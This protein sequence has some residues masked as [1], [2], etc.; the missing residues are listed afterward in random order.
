MSLAKLQ[1]LVYQQ[2]S[3]SITKGRLTHAYLFEGASGTGKKEMALW[4]TQ[5]IFCLSEGARPCA[6]C[7]NCQRILVG[8][9]PD[10]LTII[11]EG[12]TI[13]VDQIRD[14]KATFIKSGMESQKKVVIIEEAEKLTTSASNSLLKFIEEPDGD[15]IILF[16]T[17]SKARILPTIQSRCQLLHFN[18]LSKKQLSL[19]L[20]AEDIPPIEAKFLAELT[21]SKE[22][23]IEFYRDEWFNESK[24]AV[25]KWVTYLVESNHFSFVF[26][27]QKLVKQFKDKK[28]QLLMFDMLLVYFNQL[29]YNKVRGE[30]TQVTRSKWSQ[31]KIVTGIEQT[32]ISR[33]KFEANVSFQNVCEQLTITLLDG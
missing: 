17:D 6:E 23:A 9:H 33:K 32:L 21:N 10:V 11:P 22:K 3:T 12:Q 27:Q 18:P 30:D 7:H 8:D 24:E 4:L 14:I 28:Q 31:Q 20:T 2:L 25:L 29:L 15:M 26:V 19:L 1:P 5:A 16:I 13:K